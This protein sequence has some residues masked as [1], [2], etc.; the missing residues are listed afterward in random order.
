[1]RKQKIYLGTALPG[2]KVQ[3]ITS[4]RMDV[5]DRYEAQELMNQFIDKAYDDLEDLE[6][7]EDEV[8]ISD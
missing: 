4:I 1:M 7:E 8:S 5:F 3:T 6:G 2:Q